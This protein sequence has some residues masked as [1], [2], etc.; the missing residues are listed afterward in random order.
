MGGGSTDYN[1]THSYDWDDDVRVTRRSAA[2]YAKSDGREYKGRTSKGIEAPIG[3]EIKTD[4]KL[5][6]I[7]V[8]DVTGSM[9]H[10]PKLIFEKIPTLYSE[11][12]VAL[13]GIG[14]DELK[15][16]KE[17]DD[18]LEMAVIAVGDAYIDRCPL[19][20]VD[21]SGGASLAE[22]VNKIYPEG[23]GGRF[24]CES[25]ELVAYY[26]D[27]HCKIPESAKPILIYACDEDFYKKIK[28][29]HVKKFIGDD[30]GESLDS[31]EVMKNLVK[32][33]DMY[34][35]R[36]EPQGPCEVYNEAQKHWESL[37]GPQK[38][39]KMD[40]PKRLVD[41]IIGISAY[42]SDNFELGEALLKRR[43]TE[44]QVTQVLETLHP[45]IKDAKTKGG[46]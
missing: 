45:L 3:K 43:Q 31:E 30:I 29:E 35:L 22:H 21:F 36:P 19:Q 46:K 28:P 18:L 38:V 34:V 37:L 16:G 8:V 7:L 10:W 15:K 20:V 13:Q 9:E 17:V 27:K 44:V 25:Y 11:A 32:K 1:Y 42:A 12:N 24:G 4:S 14:L 41:C 6:E 5:A 2:D 23:G 26:L 33:F 39:L 40:D